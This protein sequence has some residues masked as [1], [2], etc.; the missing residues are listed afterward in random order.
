M[1]KKKRERKRGGERKK[2]RSKRKRENRG[3]PLSLYVR[4]KITF[5]QYWKLIG[6][7]K[8]SP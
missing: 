2:G 4:G 3:K 7:R 6:G 5:E 1:P 8:L